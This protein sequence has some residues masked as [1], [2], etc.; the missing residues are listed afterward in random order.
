MNSWSDTAMDKMHFGCNMVITRLQIKVSVCIW[1]IIFLFLDQNICCGC[2][3]E[4]SQWDGSF[5]HPK[6]TFKLTDVKIITIFHSQNLPSGQKW[7]YCVALIRS[8]LLISF[9]REPTIYLFLWR[10][11]YKIWI[12]LII[13]FIILRGICLKYWYPVINLP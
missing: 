8:I 7:K 1:K 13:H 4:P 3:K 12:I 5:E 11:N 6:H 9:Q 2:S 10:N